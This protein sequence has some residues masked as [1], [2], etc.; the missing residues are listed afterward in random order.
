MDQGR[1]SLGAGMASC[2]RLNGAH[3][4]VGWLLLV[5]DVRM[6][7]AYYVLVGA[8]GLVQVGY[9]VLIWRL[10]QRRGKRRTARGVLIAATL[11][12][13]VNGAVVLWIFIAALSGMH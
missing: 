7:P 8:G 4:G 2:W 13:I 11:S 9:V 3:L 6:L 12:A 5:A 1:G 10:L